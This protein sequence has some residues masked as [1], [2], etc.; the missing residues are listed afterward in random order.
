MTTRNDLV[1]G[2]VRDARAETSQYQVASE[3]SARGHRWTQSTVHKVEHGGRNLLL[4]EAADLAEILGTTLDQLAGV[5]S[6]QL[7]TTNAAEAMRLRKA[8]RIALEAL[9]DAF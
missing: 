8:A 7:A 5:D 4:T 6:A 9:R 1:G 2:R 3:M